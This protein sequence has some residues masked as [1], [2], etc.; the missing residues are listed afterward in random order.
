MNS[1]SC[2]AYSGNSY[3]MTPVTS[4]AGGSF[5]DDGTNNV[6]KPLSKQIKIKRTRKTPSKPIEAADISS[7][8]QESIQEAIQNTDVK[9]D[10]V[11]EHLG[12][13]IEE[14]YEI[15]ESY[16]KGQHLERL[17]RHQI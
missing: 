15:I 3:Q 17:V 8:I 2:E 13:Y 1:L 5:T 6:K 10:G 12:N 16:F 4:I 9:K 7:Q 14:P 11:L